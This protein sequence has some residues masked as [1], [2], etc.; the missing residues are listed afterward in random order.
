LNNVQQLLENWQVRE[1]ERFQREMV[2]R[3]I[4]MLREQL[5]QKYGEFSD[6]TELV[7]DDRSNEQMRGF[8]KGIDT[9]AERD[10][11]RL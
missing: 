3:K 1:K 6:S 7:R 10:L 8:L 2:V 11:D 5:Y 9:T 4:D